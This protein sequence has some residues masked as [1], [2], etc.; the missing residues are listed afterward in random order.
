MAY[1]TYH[2]RKKQKA[3]DYSSKLAWRY[4]ADYIR[5][6]EMQTFL[7]WLDNKNE[8]APVIKAAIAHL[9]ACTIHPFDNENEKIAKAITDMLLA[10]ADQSKQRFYSIS[11]QIQKERNDYYNIIELT[12]EGIFL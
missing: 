12:Q 3:Q 6:N 9:I 10:R 11:S 4:Y 2:N 5:P 1:C 8:I 7:I